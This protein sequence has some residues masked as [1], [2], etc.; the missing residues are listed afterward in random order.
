MYPGIIASTGTVPDF[1]T[2]SGL[3][4]SLSAGDPQP[5]TLDSQPTPIPGLLYLDLDA[6][7][8]ERL[9]QFE[10][11]FYQRRPITVT[12]GDGQQLAAEAYVVPEENRHLLTA[13]PWT[14]GEFKSRGDPARFVARYAGF[15]RLGRP[16]TNGT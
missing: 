2:K 9:D 4:P 12:T 14:A 13:E 16:P 8:L 11:D 7:S 6:D 5:S 3:S 10:S 1:S 15:H